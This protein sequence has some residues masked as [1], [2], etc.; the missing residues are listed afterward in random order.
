MVSVVLMVYK[1]LYTGNLSYLCLNNA[2]LTFIVTHFIELG[3]PTSMKL[4]F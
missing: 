1:E 4:T 3:N 2:V